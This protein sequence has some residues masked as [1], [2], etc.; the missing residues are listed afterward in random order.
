M[1]IRL[2]NNPEMDILQLLKLNRKELL[3]LCETNRYVLDL[4]NNN[5]DLYNK[6]YEE[7][8]IPNV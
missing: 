3:E 7:I 2:T 4:C 6:L 8:P 1:D 5:E